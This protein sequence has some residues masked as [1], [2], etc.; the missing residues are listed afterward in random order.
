MD[1]SILLGWL[2]VGI[3]FALAGIGSVYGTTIVG[4]AAEAALKKD[5]S[6][7]ANYMILSALPSTQ[8]LYGFVAFFMAS[9]KD[10][11]QD[12]LLWLCVGISVGAVCLLSA[13]RQGLVAANG[14]KGISEGHDVLV[15]TMIYAALPE[16]CAILALVA[17][18]LV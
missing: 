6:K 16:F 13:I 2:G 4:N 1:L 9:Q 3:M 8:G 12:G 18:L 11:S 5:P 14:C 17:A 15:P 10:F 7:S